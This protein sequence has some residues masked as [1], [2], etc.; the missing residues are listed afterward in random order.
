MVCALFSGAKEDI[1][2]GRENSRAARILL[3]KGVLLVTS[4]AFL[5]FEFMVCASSA[6]ME[7]GG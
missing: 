3:E 4:A 6:K 1:D 7:P 2:L 5:V